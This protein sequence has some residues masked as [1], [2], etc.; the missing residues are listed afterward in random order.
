MVTHIIICPLTK[1]SYSDNIFIFIFI[2]RVYRKI[3]PYHGQRYPADA[4]NAIPQRCQCYAN[5]ANTISQTLSHHSQRYPQ[6]AA[7]AIPKT[8]TLPCHRQHYPPTP[9]TI[10]PIRQRSPWLLLLPSPPEIAADDSHTHMKPRMPPITT[11]PINI[12]NNNICRVS[13]RK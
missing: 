13:S 12:T 2:F 11:C 10:S 4:R 6:E 9:P 7:N 3:I 1:C 5:A 8:P